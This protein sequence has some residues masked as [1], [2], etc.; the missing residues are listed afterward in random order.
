MRF[1]WGRRRWLSV[2]VA[3]EGLAG[4]ELGIDKVAFVEIKGV[5]EL[6]NL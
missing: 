5:L 6:V 2:R 3:G 1:V 4:E